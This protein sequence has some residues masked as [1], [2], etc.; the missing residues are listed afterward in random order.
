MRAAFLK[1]GECGCGAGAA[2]RGATLI[3]FALALVLGVLPIVLGM[4][5]VAALMVARDT[6]A[7]ATFMAARQG[8]VSGAE[9][10][11]MHRELARGLVP[12]YVRS[13]PGAPAPAAA[14]LG[15][16]GAALADVTALDSL[17]IHSPTRAAFD[18]FAEWRGG[19]RVIPN[20]SIE[21]RPPAL[22]EANVL[23]ILVV[24]CQ[25]L[26]VPIAGPALASALELLDTDPRHRRCIAAGRAPILARA[27]L[28]M[29]S[30]VRGDGLQ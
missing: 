12:L 9:P 21:F 29:Q 23:A 17:V 2:E 19:N 30:D 3:E 26:V 25:P 28:V 7:F 24:H 15:A 6:V 13:A 18:R 16:Y 5:Q 10:G 20:D 4:L 14:V 1:A 11:A 8:A 22:Q 27:S